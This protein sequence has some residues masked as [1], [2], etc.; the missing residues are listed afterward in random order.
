MFFHAWVIFHCIYVPHLIYPFHQALSTVWA[1]AIEWSLE[2]CFLQDVWVHLWDSVSFVVIVKAIGIWEGYH[3]KSFPVTFLIPIFFSR[4][5]F[6][7]YHG[8]KKMSTGSNHHIH[9]PTISTHILCF[10]LVLPIYS[11]F[12]P[13]PINELYFPLNSLKPKVLTS[14]YTYRLKPPPAAL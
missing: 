3:S 8:K 14:P 5:C 6:L 10:L 7:L 1:S 12:L 9:P 11:A 2:K 4:P 13:I